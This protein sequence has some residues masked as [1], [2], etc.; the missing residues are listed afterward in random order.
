[1]KYFTERSLY[2]TFL[3]QEILEGEAD[4]WSF[5]AKLFGVRPKEIKTYGKVL[6]D[7]TLKDLTTVQ[8]INMYRNFLNGFCTDKDEF[9]KRAEE[10]TAIEARALALHKVD[11]LFGDLLIK[12]NRLRTLSHN[13]ERDHVGAVLYALSILHMGKNAEREQ[14]AKE[15]LFKELTQGKNS[16]AGLILLKLTEGEELKT[17]KSE[18]VSTPDMLLRPDVLRRLASKYGA[19]CKGALTRK[20]TIGF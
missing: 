1:M 7:A 4:G 17:V 3:L 14:L 18:L 10:V 9:G 13:Y 19:S 5:T 8:D 16:D 11:T 6:K 15:I 12:G 20:R 2:Y